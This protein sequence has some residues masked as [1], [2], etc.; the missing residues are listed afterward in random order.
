ML[1]AGEHNNITLDFSKIGGNWPA[2]AWGW[3]EPYT[4]EGNHFRLH[5]W[6]ADQPAIDLV[7]NFQAFYFQVPSDNVTDGGNRTSL[8]ITRFE[9][10]E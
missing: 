4:G 2:D 1:P 6:G 7:G 10:H 3:D 9:I 5:P 8:K